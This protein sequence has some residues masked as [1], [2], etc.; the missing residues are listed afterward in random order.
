MSCE[1]REKI[2]LCLGW[3]KFWHAGETFS[4][5]LQVNLRAQPGKVSLSCFISLQGHFKVVFIMSR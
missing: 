5:E 2:D 3:R 4:A 1:N